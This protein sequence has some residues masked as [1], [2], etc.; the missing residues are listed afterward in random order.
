MLEIELLPARYGDCIWIRFGSKKKPRN[1]L[2]DTGFK[3][4]MEGFVERLES[5]PAKDAVF[6][7]FVLTHIDADHI[8]GGVSLLASDV[9]TKK[10][11]KRIWFNGWKQLE[12]AG[13]KHPE[14]GALQGEYFSALI[15]KKQILHNDQKTVTA[16]AAPIMVPATGKL[17]STTI[18]GFKITLLSPTAQ[19]LKKLHA[20]WKDGLKGKLKPGDEIKALELLAEDSH[21]GP[22]DTLGGLDVAKLAARKFQE[23]TAKANGSSIAFVAEYEGKTMLFGGDAFPGVLDASLRRWKPKAS[24]IELDVFKLPHHGSKNNL[25]PS[26]A[27][28]IAC[29]HALFSTDGTKFKH[30]DDACVARLVASNAA[31]KKPVEMTLHF[32]YPSVRTKPWGTATMT[33]KYGYDVNYGTAGALTLEL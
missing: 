28:R 12:A 30:P 22:L 25:S 3:K 18:D 21:Y 1:I 11:F 15:R 19:Q 33:G 16:L 8:E 10:R 4:T 6:D 14:L 32:N 24:V 31:R 27:E 13:G 5:G 26:L 7:L 2:I 17:P 20:H 29:R 9:V 23:D